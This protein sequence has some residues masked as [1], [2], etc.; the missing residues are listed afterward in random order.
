MSKEVRKEI[1]REN[2][3]WELPENLTLEQTEVG[4]M[5]AF[6][7][8]NKDAEEGRVLLNFHGGAYIMSL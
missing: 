2:R 4:E 7:I 6:W 3:A 1:L 5:Y 8:K